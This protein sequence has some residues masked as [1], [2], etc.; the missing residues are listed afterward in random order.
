MLGNSTEYDALQKIWVNSLEDVKVRLDH[1]TFDEFKALMKGQPSKPVATFNSPHLSSLLP[2]VPE[3]QDVDNLVLSD[4]NDPVFIVDGLPE[5]DNIRKTHRKQRST[6]FDHR[7]LGKNGMND[8]G[9]S[10]MTPPPGNRAVYRKHLEMRLT[11][12][13]ASKQFDKEKAFVPT[14]TGGTRA[15]LVMKR[16]TTGLIEAEDDDYQT[17]FQLAE[18]RGGRG[19]RERRRN[20]TVSDVTGMLGKAEAE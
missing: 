3:G 8:G 13:A 17:R 11:V 6:S 10:I 5:A 9:S 1:I 15:S 19:G 2:G 18:A 7:I 14:K 16:G 4:L 20:K 12:M